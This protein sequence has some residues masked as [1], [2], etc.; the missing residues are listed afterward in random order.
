VG[1]ELKCH[2]VPN[3]AIG[4]HLMHPIP[5]LSKEVNQEKVERRIVP[6]M[7]VLLVAKTVAN[8]LFLQPLILMWPGVRN[9]EK[10]EPDMLPH[11]FGQELRKMPVHGIQ[12][13]Q[14]V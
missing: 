6:L 14:G 1:T 13:Q 5:M 9:Q 10:V 4:L 12:P 3:P 7:F 2:G 8:L 11:P